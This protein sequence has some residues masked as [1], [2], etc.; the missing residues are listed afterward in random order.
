MVMLPIKLAKELEAMV[1]TA[2]EPEAARNFATAWTNYFYD[3]TATGPAVPGSLEAAKGTMQANLSGMSTPGAG[4]VIITAAITAFWGVVAGSSASI[5]PGTLSA[6]PPPGLAAIAGALN[7]V[8]PSVTSGNMKIGQA[9]QMIA[10]AI[11]PN[12]LG[13]IAVLP[14]PAP[15]VPIL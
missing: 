15:P 3:A 7:S 10:L 2:A 1:P 13:G 9:M 8:F 14:P 6:T 5:W 11:H 12:N 4:A